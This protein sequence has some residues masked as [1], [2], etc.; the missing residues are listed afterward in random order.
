MQVTAVSF[1][2]TVNHILALGWKHISF[3]FYILHIQ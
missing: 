1:D 3:F 2:A